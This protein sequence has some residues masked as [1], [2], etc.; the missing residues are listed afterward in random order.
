MVDM[1]AMIAKTTF[2]AQRPGEERFPITVS[3]GTPYRCGTDPE[4]W[5]CPVALDPLY[6][7]LRD[8]HGGSA[9]QSLCL[10]IRLAGYLLLGF[11][12]DG[13]VLTFEGGERVPLDA[14]FTPAPAR[15]SE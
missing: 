3:I 7:R 6:P 4:E 1:N 10:A 15:S 2:F 14:Y 12:E 8:Q 13:G 5:A 9:L 11:E